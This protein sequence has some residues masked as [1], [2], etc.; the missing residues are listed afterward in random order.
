MSSEGFLLGGGGSWHA[1]V[2][3]A[4]GF[5]QV[6]CEARLLPAFSRS[7]LLLSGTCCSLSFLFNARFH[8]CFLLQEWQ[9]A[10]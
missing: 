7:L 5:G 1:L 8:F 3:V 6:I 10:T 9:E 4:L 2:N